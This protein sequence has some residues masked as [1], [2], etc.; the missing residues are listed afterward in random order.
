ME[1]IFPDPTL[2]GQS[3]AYLW[4][5]SINS[6][7]ICGHVKHELRVTSSRPRVTRSNLRVMSSHSRGTSSNLQVR[8]SN[9]RVG[10]L[11]ARVARSK[12]LVGRLKARVRILKT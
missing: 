10:R 11:K 12:A 3:Q 6:L 5:N 7:E 1:K 9:A 2:K 8:S 4:I